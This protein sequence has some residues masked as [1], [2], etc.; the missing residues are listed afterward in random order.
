MIRGPGTSFCPYDAQG[1]PEARTLTSH[2]WWLLLAAGRGPFSPCGP[3][4][5]AGLSLLI[6][7]IWLLQRERSLNSV[8]RAEAPSFL[9]PGGPF[10]CPWRSRSLG[11]R[12]TARHAA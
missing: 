9:P 6:A 10:P 1:H 11:G 4:A 3:S 2:V 5:W 12:L 8:N 7:C